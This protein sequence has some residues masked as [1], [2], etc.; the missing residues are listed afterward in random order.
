MKSLEEK[1][2]FV[3][4]WL[5]LGFRVLSQKL[6]QFHEL[7]IFYTKI[8]KLFNLTLQKIR[9]INKIIFALETDLLC[10]ITGLK[11]NLKHKHDLINSTLATQF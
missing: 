5:K 4:R 7:V 10:I 6:F 3:T 11:N 8:H 9:Q 2:G 1:R